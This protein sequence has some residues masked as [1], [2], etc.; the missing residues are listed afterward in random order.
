VSI[1]CI[2][3]YFKKYNVDYFITTSNIVVNRYKIWGESYISYTN[4]NEISEIN[5]YL[6]PKAF[7]IEKY[8]CNIDDILKNYKDV[9]FLKQ[10]NYYYLYQL[11][12]MELC[13]NLKNKYANQNDVKY[14]VVFKIRP[15]MILVNNI[16]DEDMLHHLNNLEDYIYTYEYDEMKMSDCFFY[17]KNDIVNKY[18]EDATNKIIYKYKE[19][20]CEIRSEYGFR[21]LAYLSDIK[22]KSSSDKLYSICLRRS[23][24]PNMSI[25][26]LKQLEHKDEL[27]C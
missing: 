21:L 12:S 3:N 2:V 20:N 16:R 18:L 27:G 22:I 4:D 1:P 11:F 23:S 5:E 10:D 24:T 26:E 7:Y 19:T 14:D 6:N 8:Y 17:G 15:D 9:D 25:F 13:N